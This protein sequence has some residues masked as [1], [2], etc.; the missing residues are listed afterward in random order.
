M[1]EQFT[2]ADLQAEYVARGL[3]GHPPDTALESVPEK[4]REDFRRAIIGGLAPTSSQPRS[5]QLA[6]GTRLEYPAHCAAGTPS[7]TP[8][9][10]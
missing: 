2:L 10:A 7:G 5:S 9:P 4:F 8:P 6:H 3:C 1:T